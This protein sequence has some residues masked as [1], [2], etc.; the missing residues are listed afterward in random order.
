[1]VG[2]ETTLKHTLVEAAEAEIAQAAFETPGSHANPKTPNEK[3]TY[4]S[5]KTAFEDI[6]QE[7]DTD[8]IHT[9]EPIAAKS[10]RP[11]KDVVTD[12]A[13]DYNID[14]LAKLIQRVK[15][16]VNVPVTT[17]ETY[18]YWLKSRK[19]QN[20][21]DFIGAH[22][23]PYWDRQTSAEAVGFTTDT[24][25]RLR[26]EIRGKRIVI[27]EFGWPSGGY[28]HS[29]AEP[30]RLDQAMVLRQFVAR[31]D[32]LGI[33]YNIIEAF[34][35]PWKT[36]EGSVGRYWGMFDA[37]RQPKF[38]WTGPIDHADYWKIAAIAVA[39]G[40]LISLPILGGAAS[41]DNLKQGL[42]SLMGGYQWDPSLSGQQNAM[43]MAKDPS[44]LD[45]ATGVAMGVGP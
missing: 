17:G 14:E 42:Q 30:G 15:R 26:Q 43:A 6:K 41:G 34:D 40:F 45:T 37:S 19:L 9:A 38:S 16:E 11:I 22:I 33:D 25:D 23:L 35:Q 12:I 13:D 20:S 8:F 27:A 36:M 28:N 5:F 1:V 10:R 31:A 2:N 29:R 39:I 3:K 32:A 24:F 44:Q 4:R 18:N 21:V 7:W